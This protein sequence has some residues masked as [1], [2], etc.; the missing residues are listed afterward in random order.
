MTIDSNKDDFLIKGTIW[1][2]NN[3]Y[4]LYKEAH[5]PWEWHQ[6]LFEVAKD[7]NMVCF[8]SPFDQS[9]VDFLEDLVGI[10]LL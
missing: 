8:S 2:G 4:S 9:A 1:D 10:K 3:L 6:K 7:V 5:T